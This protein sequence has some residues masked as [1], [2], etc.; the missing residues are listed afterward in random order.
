MKE[1]DF[2]YST[3]RHEIDH[4]LSDVDEDAYLKASQLIWDSE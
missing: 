3:V 4:L 2:Y 1:L